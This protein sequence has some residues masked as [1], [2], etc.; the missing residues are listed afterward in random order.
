MS[1]GSHGGLYSGG[2]GGGGG[3][4]PRDYFRNSHESDDEEVARKFNKIMDDSDSR[5]NDSLNLLEI[6]AAQQKVRAQTIDVNK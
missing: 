4:N 1:G 6:S 3:T 5:S 2:F